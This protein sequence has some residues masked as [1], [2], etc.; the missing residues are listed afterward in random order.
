MERREHRRFPLEVPMNFIWKNGQHIS[1]FGK[2]L[3]RDVSTKGLFICAGECP[4]EG[5]LVRFVAS[6]RLREPSVLEFR[7]T[8]RV[9]R[10]ESASG[11]HAREG[12]AVASKTPVIKHNMMPSQP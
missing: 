6:L 3:T 11:G 7:A 12:F 9:V 2:G 10:V 1:H 8:A 4:P 5:S